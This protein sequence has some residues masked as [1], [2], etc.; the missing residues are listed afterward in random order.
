MRSVLAAVGAVLAAAAIAAPAAAA[1]PSPAAIG[2]VI[3]GVQLSGRGVLVNYPSRAVPRLPKI[4]ASAWVIADAGTGQ[5]LA[6]KDPH[7]WY[8]PAS[9]LKV[10]TAISLI[11]ALNPNAMVVASEAGHHGVAEHRAGCCR[12]IPTRS[13]TCSPRC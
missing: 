10:L 1:S 8:R 4:K 13:P 6:A 12:G 11:P 9:T 3:G 7:G 5:V 2:P